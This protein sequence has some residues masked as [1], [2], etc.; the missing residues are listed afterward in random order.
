M[1]FVL[2]LHQWAYYDRLLD[3][4][5]LGVYK[6]VRHPDQVTSLAVHIELSTTIIAGQ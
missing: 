2:L 5:T 3:I 6:S 4:A 1:A